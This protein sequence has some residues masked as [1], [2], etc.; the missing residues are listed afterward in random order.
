MI[1]TISGAA[2]S[3]KSTIAKMLAKKLGWPR[4]YIGG[5]RRRK[6]K[7]KGMTLAEYNKLGETDPSTDLEVDE[8]QKKLGKKEDNFIMEG[9]TSWYFI[10]HSFKIY[11]DVDEKEG[12]KRIFEDLKKNRG[13]NEG[14]NLKS[15]EDVL[16][17]MRE[18]KQ[19][20]IKRYKKYY[21]INVY[22]KSNYDY[23]LDTTDLSM[24]EVFDRIY[25]VVLK[26]IDK[27]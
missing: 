19:S 25:M 8:Y 7:E 10:P 22:D 11:L 17:S 20:D 24:D 1:I 21:N 14:K 5:L 27:S 3:G 9:R 15:R 26:K 16:K 23:A 6:A 12:A 13:R 18:R 2:G 4:Y